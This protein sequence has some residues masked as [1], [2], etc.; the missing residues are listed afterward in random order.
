MVPT[1]P[2]LSL[3]SCGSPRSG[4]V[5]VAVLSHPAVG[6]GEGDCV[7]Y[8]DP[9]VG[10]AETGLDAAPFAAAGALRPVDV[11]GDDAGGFV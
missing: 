6:D 9:L 2:L 5:E 11:A 10:P 7:I 3:S 4:H 8:C 1:T